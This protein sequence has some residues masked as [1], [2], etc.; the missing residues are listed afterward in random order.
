M[1]RLGKFNARRSAP[2]GFT[3]IEVLLAAL[4]SSVLLAGLWSLL[5]GYLRMF[6]SGQRQT[7][8]AQ[9]VRSVIQELTAD[10]QAVAFAPPPPPEA[11]QPPMSTTSGALAGGVA[12]AAP[13]TT[14]SPRQ[15]TSGLVG[16]TH[17][18]TIDVV[19]PISLLEA[20][21]APAENADEPDV[22]HAPELRTVV[23]EVRA[24]SHGGHQAN[25][26]ATS[27]VRRT[28]DWARAQSAAFRDLS[29]RSSRLDD[30]SDDG[31]LAGVQGVEAAVAADSP[32]G[33]A[34]VVPEVQDLALRYFD[35]VGWVDAWDTSVQGRLPAAVEATITLR[36]AE[37]RHRSVAAASATTTELQS[38]RGASYRTVIV[39]NARPVVPSAPRQ[40]ETP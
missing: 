8:E 16:T 32:S 7:E 19:R 30:V 22:P 37:S 2:A 11:S 34:I 31:E 24:N 12:G 38:P 21:A 29:K 4:L 35:G 25:L 40:Q 23:Y 17:S 15:P 18:I 3:L 20:A 36:P 10:L 28:A 1:T 6:D 5:T 39:L 14:S 26:T 9:L 33:S 27:L 13:A